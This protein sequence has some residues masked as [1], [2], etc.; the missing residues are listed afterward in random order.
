MK[1]VTEAG[2]IICPANP[3]FYSI[4]KSIE[5]VAQTVV[6]RVIDFAGLTGQLSLEGRKSWNL[7]MQKFVSP[8]LNLK[9]YL[10]SSD[11]PLILGS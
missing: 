7:T 6:S 11:E 4:P 1:T 3:S 10:C 5:E 8:K 9:S 2:G